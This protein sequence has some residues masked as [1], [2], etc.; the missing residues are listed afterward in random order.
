MM[1]CI[2]VREFANE[3]ASFKTTSSDFFQDFVFVVIIY[4]PFTI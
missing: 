4:Y 3:I 1:G 2:W